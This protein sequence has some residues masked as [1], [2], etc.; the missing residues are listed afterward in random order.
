MLELSIQNGLE[1][2]YIP[3]ISDSLVLKCGIKL[4]DEKLKL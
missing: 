4:I 2:R 1:N 3:L